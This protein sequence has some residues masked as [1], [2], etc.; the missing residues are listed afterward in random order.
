MGLREKI[1]DKIKKKE[2]EI[3]DYERK[4]SEARS[5]MEALK[6]TIKL[7]PKSEMNESAESKIRPGSAIAKTLALLKK[8]GRPMHLNEILEGIG[9]QTTKKERVALSGSL[10][11]YVRKHEVFIRTAPNTFGLIG[12]ESD[13]EEKPPEDFGLEKTEEKEDETDLEPF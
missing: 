3:A 4:I 7:L 13:I 2:Q 6:D 1:E 11:W 8:T 9:K 12:M 5:Y 10:G